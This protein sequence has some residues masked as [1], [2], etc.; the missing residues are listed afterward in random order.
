MEQDEL[1]QRCSEDFLNG[2]GDRLGR[3]L[4]RGKYFEN[5]EPSILNPD[6]IGKRPSGIDGY[7]QW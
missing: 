6:A 1:T 5:P 4:R 3:I 2:S 7:A